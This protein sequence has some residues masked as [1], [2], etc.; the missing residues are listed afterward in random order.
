M[1]LA[2]PSAHDLATGLIVAQIAAPAKSP[3]IR[4]IARF[5]FRTVM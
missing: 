1:I 3:I 4:I 2:L 5:A